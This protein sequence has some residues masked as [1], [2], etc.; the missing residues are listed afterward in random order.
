M[1]KIKYLLFL[2]ILSIIFAP[3]LSLA[4]YN[5]VTWGP[6]TNLYFSGVAKEEGGDTGITINVYDNT[7]LHS[8]ILDTRTIRVTMYPGS[9]ISLKSLDRKIFTTNIDTADTVCTDEYSVFTYSTPST[10][11]TFTIALSDDANCPAVAKE[12][13][14]DV[15]EEEEEINVENLDHI[16]TSGFAFL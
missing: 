11:E 6:E 13:I 9:S 7:Y 3:N 15:A 8:Y 5:T 2:L 4:V 12:I 16:T 1:F 14:E 10:T